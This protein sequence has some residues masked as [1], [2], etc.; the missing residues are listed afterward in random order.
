MHRRW[1]LTKFPSK[2]QKYQKGAKQVSMPYILYIKKCFSHILFVCNL[3]F[4]V[5]L[6]LIL[7]LVWCLNVLSFLATY[8]SITLWFEINKAPDHTPAIGCQTK[9]EENYADAQF[10][11]Y[12][13][14]LD[15]K[16]EK[17][18]DLELF[19]HKRL[20]NVLISWY[21]CLP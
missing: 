16:L 15:K 11:A 2:F 12:I 4:K 14:L 19:W 10:L 20:V 1:F 9:K 7:V 13:Y 8:L 21:L 17:S 18:Q 3:L 5:S 6:V